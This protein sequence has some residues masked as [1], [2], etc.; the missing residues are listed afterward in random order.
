MKISLEIRLLRLTQ[1]LDKDSL[2]S[3][4]MT[5][6][7]SQ[8]AVYTFLIATKSCSQ[9]AYFLHLSKNENVGF[10][11]AYLNPSDCSSCGKFSECMTRQWSKIKWDIE[12]EASFYE[13]LTSCLLFRHT[14]FAPFTRPPLHLS[15]IGQ[16]DNG[17]DAWIGIDF[18]ADCEQPSVAA[19]LFQRTKQAPSGGQITSPLS[20]PVS[21]RVLEVAAVGG[22]LQRAPGI[23]RSS[24]GACAART[25][26][27]IDEAPDKSAKWEMPGPVGSSPNTDRESL[28][29][30]IA[31]VLPFFIDR[32]FKMRI[33]L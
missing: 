29:T 32:K 33:Y 15:P 20:H 25:L 18:R 5:Q 8:H 27:A 28:R 22:Q 16:A 6:L 11:T 13:A 21:R 24:D 9:A 14:M 26:I 10:K 2:L 1:T 23:R 7:A 4:N 12:R 30:A 17:S 31:S 19:L 3:R